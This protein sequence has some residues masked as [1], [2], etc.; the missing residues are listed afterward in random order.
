MGWLVGLVWLVGDSE[1]AAKSEM[2][3]GG[4]TD[5]VRATGGCLCLCSRRHCRRDPLRLRHRPREPPGPAPPVLLLSFDDFLLPTAIRIRM[6][7]RIY[8]V[9]TPSHEMCLFFSF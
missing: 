7:Y 8:D 3:Y 6:D 1:W 4:G 5:A 2:S 9:L